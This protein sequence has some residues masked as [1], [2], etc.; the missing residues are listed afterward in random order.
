M[1]SSLITCVKFVAAAQVGYLGVVGI[2]F[3]AL[4]D[5]AKEKCAVARSDSK[6]LVIG[7]E[8]AAGHYFSGVPVNLKLE[9]V[10]YRERFEGDE[11][12]VAVAEA[13]ESHLLLADS[14]LLAASL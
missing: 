4:D 13:H 1:L 11:L 12:E 8:L 6:V 14:A 10:L 9:T 7:A 2:E 5:V 3:L